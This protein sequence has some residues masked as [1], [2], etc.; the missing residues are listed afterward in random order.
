MKK[1]DVPQ[2]NEGLHEGK[3]RDLCYVVDEKGKYTE[4]LSTGWAPKNAAMMQAWDQVNEV[5]EETRQKV[6]SGKLSPLAYHM[7]KNIMNIKLLAKYTG[8]AKRKIK[9]HLKPDV[10]K[11]LDLQT[12]EKYSHVFNITVEQL[13]R[14]EDSEEN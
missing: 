13:T 12:L 4:A 14:V 11:G 2:D 5:V 3:F 6:L 7:E 9:K 8:L 1:K 10:F